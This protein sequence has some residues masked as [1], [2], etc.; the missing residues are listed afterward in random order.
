MEFVHPSS[1]ARV[2]TMLATTCA[3]AAPSSSPA[4]AP[5]RAADAGAEGSSPP[6]LAPCRRCCAGL[7]HLQ[8]AFER[9]VVSALNSV[10][11]ARDVSRGCFSSP[12]ASGALS[13]RASLPRST[14]LPLSVAELVRSTRLWP[15]TASFAHYIVLGSLVCG[16]VGGWLLLLSSPRPKEQTL[17]RKLSPE[18]L[19]RWV[20]VNLAAVP[21]ADSPRVTEIKTSTYLTRFLRVSSPACLRLG[22]PLSRPAG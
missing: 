8:N 6:P 15:P 19:C 13:H 3:G 22:P 20:R 11:G 18:P 2:G 5:R 9:K 1:L 14:P 7:P 21:S 16:H 10:Q 4:R 17:L 12:A